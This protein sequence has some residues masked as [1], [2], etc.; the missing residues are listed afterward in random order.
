MD[1]RVSVLYGSEQFSVW[2]VDSD[3]PHGGSGRRRLRAL[4]APASGK[5]ASHAPLLLPCHLW[6]QHHRPRWDRVSQSGEARAEAIRTAGAIVRDEGER[7][8]KGTEWQMN[9]TDA[10]DQSLFKLR[11][12]ADDQGIAPDDFQGTETL[13]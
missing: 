4:R 8:W 3:R 7:F 5:G 1:P 11:F 10:S 12:S 2:P 6:P 9:V 13:P